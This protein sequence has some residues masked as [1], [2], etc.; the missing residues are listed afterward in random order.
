M[1]TRFE[2]SLFQQPLK[3]LNLGLRGFAVTVLRGTDRLLDGALRHGIKAGCA[4]YQGGDFGV[5]T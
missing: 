1:T 4:L 5:K 3:V 2:N